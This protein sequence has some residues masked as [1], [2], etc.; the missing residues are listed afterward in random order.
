MLLNG[1]ASHTRQGQGR[2][3]DSRRHWP[4]NSLFSTGE[5]EMERI[6][7]R[8]IDQFPMVL[9]TL[10]S[11]V[12]ALALELL[13]NHL[14]G[15]PDLYELS[16]VA[17]Q[18]WLQAVASLVGIILIW[19]TYSGMVMRFRWT[20]ST[21]DSVLPFFVGLIEFLMIDMMGPDKIGRWLFVLAIV[22]ATMIITSHSVFRRARHDPANLGWFE[23]YSPATW[24]DFMP[25]VVI[26]LAMLIFGGWLWQ[27]GNDGWPAL[28][29]LLGAHAILGHETY[30]A[31]IFWERSMEGG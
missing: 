27:S 2:Y 31:W 23:K 17:L 1:V 13:W 19:L 22:F 30:K 28:F 11:I 26:I 14:R 4:Q 3:R 15:R 25:Q 12:Q 16:W 6:R 20:P 7:N 10:V 5:Y 18:G 8:A 24:R 9:L 21:A 29:A